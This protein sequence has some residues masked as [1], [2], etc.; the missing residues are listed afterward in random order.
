[1]KGNIVSL[2]INLSQLQLESGVTVETGGN[3]FSCLEVY[4]AGRTM[5]SGTYQIVNSGSALIEDVAC[6]MDY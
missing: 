2:G 4:E 1:M 3:Y 6:P 5:G